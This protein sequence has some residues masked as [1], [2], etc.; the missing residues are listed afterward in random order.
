MPISTRVYKA[1]DSITGG[2]YWLF[3]S[4]IV[5]TALALFFAFP[6]YNDIVS[7][8]WD[9]LF[10]K[11]A[12]PFANSTYGAG[13]H[14]AKITFRLLVPLILHFTHFGIAGTLVFLGIIG[15]LNFY[16]VVRLA[17]DMLQDKRQ[18]FILGLC[19][20]F[21]YFGKCSF[22]ELRGTMFDGIAIF[23][24]LCALNFRKPLLI[25]LFVFLA[26]WCDERA[27]V[28]STL[29]WLYYML[30]QPQGNIIQKSFSAHTISVYVAWVAYAA[31]R[32]LLVRTY[33]LTTSLEGVG[34]SVLLNQINNVPMGIWSALEGLWIPV[35]YAGIMLYRN[36]RYFEML[37]YAGICCIILLA[38]L[39]VVDIT[40]SVVYLFPVVFAAITVLQRY[41]SKEKLNQLLWF[42]LILCF[43]YPAY[44]TGGKSSIW[45]TYPLP[46]QMLRFI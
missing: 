45:W 8:D 20:A 11:A 34:L 1:I 41:V 18:A 24:L 28:G 15:V 5:L 13:T 25:A 36:K 42:A 44:Y 30:R 35:L 32:Y 9:A 12:A 19:S 3:T 16:M 26:A 37:K 2:K 22:I 40:R 10:A 6:S 17:F 7:K 31:V 14:E 29:V 39:M 38:G 43:V 23:L 27:L 4:A 21:I 46:L 33:G